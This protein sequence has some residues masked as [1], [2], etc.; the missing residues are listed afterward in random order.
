VKEERPAEKN[1]ISVVLTPAEFERFDSYCSER[2][3]KKSPLIARLIREHMTREG[4]QAQPD[5]FPA[6]QQSGRAAAARGGRRQR[7]GGSWKRRAAR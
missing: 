2:G 5:L 3:Y 7:M 6:S 1:K 4:F